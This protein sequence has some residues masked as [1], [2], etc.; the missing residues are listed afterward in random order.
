ME[1]FWGKGGGF[2]GWEFEEMMGMGLKE[3]A[4]EKGKKGKKD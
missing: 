4:R 1:D 2:V 3:N